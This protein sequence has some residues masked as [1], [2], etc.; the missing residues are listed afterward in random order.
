MSADLSQVEPLS[1]DEFQK[2]DYKTWRAEAERALKGAPFEKKLVSKSYED[3]DLQPIYNRADIKDI[4]ESFPGFSPFI[5]SARAAGYFSAPWEISQSIPY[6]SAREF[7]SA[8]RH[9]VAKGQTAVRLSLDR[10]GRLGRD[11]DMAH[12]GDV[13]FCGTSIATA[14]D[15]KLALK[16]LDGVSLHLR[17]GSG[18]LPM[19]ALLVAAYRRLG[20]DTASL[21]GVLE[22]D[23]VG[24]LVS[25]GNLPQS[26]E[27]SFNQMALVTRWALNHM[28]HLDTICVR[29]DAYSDA[30]GNA[31]QELAFALA[32]GV[33]YLREMSDRG[34]SV[35]EAA[36]NMR[37]TFL[38]GGDFY[39]AI[40]KLRAARALWQR[41][42]AQCGG[43]EDSQ[44]MHIHARTALWNKT[45]RDPYVNML[46][47]TTEA[48]AAV[49][50]GCDS[51]QVGAFDE[52]IRPPDEFSRRIARNTQ[53]I[54]REECQLDRVIDPAGGSWL[55]E[56]LT[57]QL[58]RK[59]WKLFQEIEGRGGMTKAI[60]AGFPQE[61]V[62][63]VGE[64][65]AKSIAQRRMSLVGTNV[66]ANPLEKPLEHRE[67]KLDEVQK[68]RSAEIADYR[69]VGG[70]LEQTTLLEKLSR[71]IESAPEQI[72]DSAIEA[73][74]CGATLGEIWRT[75]RH[76]EENI[77][78]ASPLRLKRG[79]APFEALYSAV[80]AAS[81]KVF[82]ANMGP[83]RQHKIR[84][85]FTISF[86]QAGGYDVLGNAGFP[87]P[88][89]AATAALDSGA[90]VI[91]ICSTDDT[92]PDI[93]PELVK[94]IKRS[95][96]ESVVVVAGYPES[97][98]ES[99]KESGVD[100]FI[101]IR[102]NCYE[103]LSKIAKSLD[104][105]S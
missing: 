97:H 37:F 16:G 79:A 48:C 35:D 30:G 11:P 88:E 54:L 24:E 13:G 50:G 6:G 1:L 57:N 12:A 93:V 64:V 105:L 91:V 41:I 95:K 15:L 32:T 81:G 19:L 51:M 45:V 14:D 17:P 21:C 101:H 33:Q 89:A 26:L 102:A 47:N 99:F 85:D 76:G 72:V 82:L 40:A 42:V 78:A 96:P 83:V 46:R 31:V 100:E 49:I 58:G 62:R 92:Y 68:K 3:I 28:P 63:K 104:I 22:Q 18:G 60:L 71:M 43:N 70:H 80:S 65:R 4:Q 103:V 2:T 36:S 9:D 34:L 39:M 94:T 8:A 44:K 29:T 61:E 27:A 38:I 69:T 7:N 75:L 23:P 25:D 67:W 86:F 77:P 55:I 87:T 5:R 66:Y 52:V 53:I 98:I 10:A 73:A 90:R 74:L 84:A 56:S 59:G 20:Y